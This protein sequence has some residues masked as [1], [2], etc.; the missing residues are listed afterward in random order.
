MESEILHLFERAQ[1]AVARADWVTLFSLL[2]PSL[3]SKIGKNS[4]LWALENCALPELVE[5]QAEYRA[6]SRTLQ[7][8]AKR[9]LQTPMPEQMQLSLQHRDLVKRGDQLLEA[10]LKQHSPEWVGQLEALRREAGA[11]GSVSSNLFAGETLEEIVCTGNRA[12][13]LRRYTGGS[14]E[15]IRFVRRRDGWK[16][17][18]W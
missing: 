4:L 5:T 10:C 16:I 13:A 18:L 8:S 2:E 7:D 6:W 15:R 3:V 1:Q 9:I 14:S 17:G 11:G 12:S